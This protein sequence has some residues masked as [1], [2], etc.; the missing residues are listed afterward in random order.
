MTKEAHPSICY[1]VPSYTADEASHMAHLPH[2]L[3]EVGKYCHLHV[4]IQR[5][6]GKPDIP[7][8]RSVYVQ[9]PGNHF[10]RALELI[11][12]AYRLRRQGCKKFLAHV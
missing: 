4:I 2:F 12:V 9:R 1:I 7:N 8:V 3:S 5:G 6:S 10:Q 11:R